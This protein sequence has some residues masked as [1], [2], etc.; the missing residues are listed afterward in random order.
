MSGTTV[1]STSEAEVAPEPAWVLLRRMCAALNLSQAE[2]AR[3]TGYSTKHINQV[4]Q[5]VAGISVPLAVDLERELGQQ[6]GVAEAL[7]SAQT[8]HDL[9]QRRRIIAG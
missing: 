2:L 5:G 7:L 9:W 4:L 3:R 6:S 1:T 8:R